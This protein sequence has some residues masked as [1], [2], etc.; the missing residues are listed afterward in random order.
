MLKRVGQDKMGNLSVT[1]YSIGQIVEE[2]TG[3]VSVH[4]KDSNVVQLLHFDCVTS[5]FL[6]ANTVLQDSR[7]ASAA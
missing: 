2:G 1:V 3:A 5:A 7:L 4:E 6:F